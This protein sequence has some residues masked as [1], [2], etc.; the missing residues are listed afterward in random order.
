MTPEAAQDFRAYFP[1]LFKDEDEP[2]EDDMKKHN[3]RRAV[4]EMI[5]EE[6]EGRTNRVVEDAFE[7]AEDE[8]EDAFEEIELICNALPASRDDVS[9][10]MKAEVG[11][12]IRQALAVL[13]KYKRKLQE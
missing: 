4:Q 8:L 9:E 2:D 3:L 12:H 13:E 1:N 6:L 5:Q 7:E 11:G 10:K